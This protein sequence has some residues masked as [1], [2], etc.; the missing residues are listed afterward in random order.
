MKIDYRDKLEKLDTTDTGLVVNSGFLSEIP[1]KVTLEGFENYIVYP[2][3]GVIYSKFNDRFIGYRDEARI[4]KCGRKSTYA[5]VRLVG[6][7]HTIFGT[8]AHIIWLFVFGSVP[9]G[10]DIHHRDGNSENDS[11]SNLVMLTVKEHRR[12]HQAMRCGEIEFRNRHG[13]WKRYRTL[14]E[15]A[16]REGLKCSTLWKKKYKVRIRRLKP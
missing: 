5:Q 16:E 11:I 4:E 9:K 7:E 6:R 14:T 8:M 3:E 1:N 10:Y 15:C 2:H 12:I 13:K